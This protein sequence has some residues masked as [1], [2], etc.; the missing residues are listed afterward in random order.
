MEPI[1][2]FPARNRL[3]IRIRFILIIAVTATVGVVLL[4]NVHA[5]APGATGVK[6]GG[7]SSQ[8]P[9][10]NAPTPSG[11]AIPT[12]NIPDWREVFS[13]D[14]TG[15]KLDPSKWTAY[16]GPAGGAPDTL[17]DQSHISV[18]DGMLQ[19][20]SY[21]DKNDD[22]K[23]V[24][25]GISSD[26]GLRQ[27]YGKY[28]VRFRFD[29]GDGITDILLL[30]PASNEWPPEIDFAENSGGDRSSMNATLF[31]NGAADQEIQHTVQADF[32]QWH[33]MGVEWEPGMLNYTLD[34]K[35]WATVQSPDVP[36]VPMSL[37]IQTQ[38]GVCGNPAN[39][40]PDSSTPKQVNMDIDWVVAYAPN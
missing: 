39:P 22:N 10:V 19:L 13:D 31:Y 6:S 30:W 14:F 27:T 21:R 38:A 15:T 11:Q 17:W 5:I 28:L 4:I 25:A 1:K 40:C 2:P 23:W 20:Q 12:G 24:S 16:E 26:V 33:T 18:Q 35:V 7:V 9:V 8:P 29:K 37:D 34:G 36:T 32:S 3:L